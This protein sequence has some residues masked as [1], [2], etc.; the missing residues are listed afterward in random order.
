MCVHCVSSQP[1]W[2]LLPEVV[3][4]VWDQSVL[5]EVEHKGLIRKYYA[6]WA[7]NMSLIY[8]KPE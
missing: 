4:S 2:Q 8:G 7:V 1:H 3:L 6:L 5:D